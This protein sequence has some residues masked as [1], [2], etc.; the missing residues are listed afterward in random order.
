MLFCS[1]M[2][3]LAEFKGLCDPDTAKLPTVAYFHENQITYPARFD[4]EKDLHFGFTNFTTALAADQVWFNSAF[5][6]ESFLGGL[7]ELLGRMPDY[8]PREKVSEIREKSFVRPQGIHPLPPRPQRPPG[9]PHI[10][11]AARWEHDKNPEMFFHALAILIE[12]GLDFKVSV[13]GQQFEETP[14]IFEETRELLGDRVVNWGYQNTRESYAAALN[15]ADIVVSTADHEFFGVGIVEAIAAGAYPLLPNRLA[16]PEILAPEYVARS[17][18]F[19]YDGS[20]EDLVTNLE[21]LIRSTIEGELWNRGAA[22][23]GEAMERFEWKRLA[24]DLD[25]ALE[26]LVHPS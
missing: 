6:R 13:I 8:S 22:R 19:F 9:A 14:K 1:D 24:P 25:E 17:E 26:T 10:L 2:L 5:H 23:P 15:E 11:W 7:K 12:R 20:P 18:I 21:Q 16:Y 4:G 3:N